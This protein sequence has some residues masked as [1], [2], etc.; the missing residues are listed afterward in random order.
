MKLSVLSLYNTDLTQDHEE[1]EDR[2]KIMNKLISKVHSM[3]LGPKIFGAYKALFSE[4]SVETNS[5]SKIW[6]HKHLNLETK[7]KEHTLTL[8]FAV[9]HL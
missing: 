3:Y 6:L 7:G 4:F 9:V 8:P 1:Q 2:S 5:F